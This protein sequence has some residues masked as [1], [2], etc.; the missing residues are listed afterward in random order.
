MKNKILIILISLF[1]VIALN[2]CSEEIPTEKTYLKSNETIIENT[3][4]NSKFSDAEIDN[5]NTNDA[6]EAQDDI[7]VQSWET[8]TNTSFSTTGQTTWTWN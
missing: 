6:T 5:S 7:V 3:K 4:S 1:Q 8:A 2:S